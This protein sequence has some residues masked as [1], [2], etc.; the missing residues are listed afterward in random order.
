[1][2]KVVPGYSA[3]GISWQEVNERIF[4]MEWNTEGY[5]AKAVAVQSSDSAICS[6]ILRAMPPTLQTANESVVITGNAHISWWALKPHCESPR[7]LLCLP[8]P[9][10]WV[11]WCRHCLS[12]PSQVS[13]DLHC[14]SRRAAHNSAMPKGRNEVGKADPTDGLRSLGSKGS[15]TPELWL[16]G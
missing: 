12:S 13:A 10:W 6:C 9:P 3:T 8:L 2:P 11:P 14:M 1:M 15:H 4:P 5:H 7:T 16:N